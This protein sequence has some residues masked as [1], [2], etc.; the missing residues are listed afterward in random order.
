[1][2]EVRRA[3]RGVEDQEGNQESKEES[4]KSKEK[5]ER[6]QRNFYG[7]GQHEES[8][9]AVWREVGG[10]GGKQESKMTEMEQ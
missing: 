8:M 2:W 3:K 9:R 4:M 5:S 6:A 1:M 7:R 10:L